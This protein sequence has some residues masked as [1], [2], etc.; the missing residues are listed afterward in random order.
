LI[1]CP[2]QPTEQTL[3]SPCSRFHTLIQLLQLDDGNPLRS[4]WNNKTSVKIRFIAF[5]RRW[6][7]LV[8]F[9]V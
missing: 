3:F 9:W 4:V 5:S 7:H 6:D 8:T 1:A 2:K